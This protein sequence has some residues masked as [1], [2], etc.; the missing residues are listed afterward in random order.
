MGAPIYSEAGLSARDIFFRVGFSVH[1]FVE[2]EGKEN[3][4]EELFSRLLKKV[5]G[6]KILPLGGKKAVLQHAESTL[7]INDIV[8]LYLLDKDFDDLLGVAVSDERI[9]YTDEYCIE[10][11]LIEENS[12][13]Q[14]AV[15]ESPSIRRMVVK[16]KINFTSE[17][18][19]W[20][21]ALDRL[22]RALYLAKRHDLPMENCGL[23]VHRFTMKH[24]HSCLDIEKIVFYEAEVARRLFDVGV[25]GHPD[26]YA[27]LARLAFGSARVSR[28]YIS[29]KHLQDL[30]VALLRRRNLLRSSVRTESVSIR[31]ARTSKLTRLSILRRK[32]NQ[33]VRR[34]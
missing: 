3:F 34:A 10:S 5:G 9:L 19:C 26:E 2:D 17:L 7:K 8:R 29:G 11:A 24:D 6:L 32:I 14:F 20:L 23:S 25:I 1:L 28:K 18:K 15:E 27:Q 4:Y 21:H 31:L 12:I 33:L 30:F 16:K 13:V 22:H